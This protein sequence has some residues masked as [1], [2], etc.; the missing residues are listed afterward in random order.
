MLLLF[1]GEGEGEGE[2]IFNLD[3]IINIAIF[4]NAIFVCH[5]KG[6]WGRKH[7]SSVNT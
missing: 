5:E 4:N 7:S 1:W 3:H 2:F 6:G